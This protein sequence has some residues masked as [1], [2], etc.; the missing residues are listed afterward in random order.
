MTARRLRDRARRRFVY[1][2]VVAHV[3]FPCTPSNLT[4]RAAQRKLFVVVAWSLDVA[5]RLR[6]RRDVPLPAQAGNEGPFRRAFLLLKPRKSPNR[7]RLPTY[8]ISP[9]GGKIRRRARTTCAA[10]CY[11]AARVSCARVG[12]ERDQG[13]RPWFFIGGAAATSRTRSN[14]WRRIVYAH[15]SA[16][17]STR[18]MRVHRWAPRTSSRSTPTPARPST[19]SAAGTYPRPR[20]VSSPV[21]AKHGR[22]VAPF[23]AHAALQARPAEVPTTLHDRD[24][25]S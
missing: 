8:E 16:S 3:L 15:V 11:A 13:V 7:E 1:A 21:C 25:L 24:H 22:Y 10:Y 2:A 20:F 4:A 5:V 18:L 19:A 6:Y 12:S 17:A 14:E 23:V 9:P